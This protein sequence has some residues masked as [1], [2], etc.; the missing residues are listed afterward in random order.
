[1]KIIKRIIQGFEELY[2]LI[3]KLSV[4]WLI[5][6]AMFTAICAC[7]MFINIFRTS[8]PLLHYEV[9]EFSICDLSGS[10]EQTKPIP[11]FSSEEKSLSACGYLQTNMPITLSV[12][13][14]YEG[15][16]IFRDVIRGV[17]GR[18][19]SE[20]IPKDKKFLEGNYEIHLVIGKKIIKKYKFVIE[21]L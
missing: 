11:V 21:A 13:W 8:P 5:I 12:D 2:D 14:F 15:K 7:L 19:F 3:I 9:I 4:T 18:F 20:L 10:K 17:E 6:F 1:M 16:I